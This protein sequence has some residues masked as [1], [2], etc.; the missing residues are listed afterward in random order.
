[1]NILEKKRIIKEKLLNIYDE[2]GTLNL[3]IDWVS[4]TAIYK[5][6]DWNVKT[7]PKTINKI[8]DWLEKNDYFNNK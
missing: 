1:M 4:A 5:F 6:M 3:K 2:M 7:T 8:Y